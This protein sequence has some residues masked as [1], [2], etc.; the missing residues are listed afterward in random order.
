[1]ASDNF[2]EL[3]DVEVNEIL[4]S[5]AALQAQAEGIERRIQ[6][7][8]E[9]GDQ[10]RQA[11]NL[12]REV[13]GLEGKSTDAPT[14][15]LFATEQRAPLGSV[16]QMSYEVI[17]R[18]GGPMKVREIATS[19]HDAG[20]FPHTEPRMQYA[21]VFGILRRDSR[22]VKVGDGLFEI[23]ERAR[24][25]GQPALEA[26]VTAGL[27]NGLSNEPVLPP[28]LSASVLRESA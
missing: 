17:R 20:K 22:F 19:L 1:M 9:R 18:N 28:E 21:T 13:M 8:L 11:A 23:R 2:L 14:K 24:V 6:D 12:Y 16:A 3:A 7:L 4:R 5:V 27:G 10:L 25:N 26:K 15:E